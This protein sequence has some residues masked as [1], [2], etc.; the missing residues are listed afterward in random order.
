MI[1]NIQWYTSSIPTFQ[2][3]EYFFPLCVAYDPVKY[4][5]NI[6]YIYTLSSMRMH[7]R[8]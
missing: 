1:L 6:A 8:R 7:K 5:T 2:Q 3:Y 4:N